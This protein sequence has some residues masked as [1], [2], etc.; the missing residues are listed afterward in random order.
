MRKSTVGVE[1]CRG[2][3]IDPD[4]F[5]VTRELVRRAAVAAA[6]IEYP[7]RLP[8][9]DFRENRRQEELVGVLDLSIVPFVLG[10][11]HAVLRSRFL[12]Q[13]ESGPSAPS[14]R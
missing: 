12:F 9:A 5:G 6:E 14:R 4:D 7:R 8:I 2:A 1:D 11:D 13:A 10:F 3:G